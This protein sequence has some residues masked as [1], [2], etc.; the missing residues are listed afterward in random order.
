MLELLT[1]IE[2]PFTGLETQYAQQKF[3]RQ[4]MNLVVRNQHSQCMCTSDSTF[5]TDA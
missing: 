5:L 3:F 4:H 1:S 2:L